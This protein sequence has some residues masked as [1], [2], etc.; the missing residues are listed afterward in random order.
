M[1]LTALGFL[2]LYACGLILCLFRHPI[3]GLYSYIFV[4][5]LDAPSRWWGASLPSVRWTLVIAG[6]TLLS[7]IALRMRTRPERSPFLSHP[8]IVFFLAFVAL[9]FVQSVWVITEEHGFGLNYFTK[10]AVVLYL[11]YALV[12]SRQRVADFLLCHVL[13]CF[14]LGLLAFSSKTGGRLDGV[15]GPGIDDSSTLGM[16]MATAVV[17]AATLY[18]ISK[19][20]RKWIP[21]L[22][23]PFLLNTVVQSGSR[24]AFLALV[25]GGLAMFW[26]RP[27]GQMGVVLRYGVLGLILFGYVASDFFWER[28]STIRAAA[29]QT[30]EIDTSAAT[31]LAIIEKQWLMA[32]DHPLGVGHKGTLALGPAYLDAKSMSAQGGRSSHNTFMSALVDQGFIGLLLWVLVMF[33]LYRRSKGVRKWAAS[34]GNTEAGWLCSGLFGMLCVIWS[35]GMFASFIRVEI[36]IW[37][38][39]LTCCLFATCS[40][41]QQTENVSMPGKRPVRP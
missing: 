39:A 34:V 36:Y 10:Y 13:G 27:P 15:G 24:G 35:G 18:L 6:A 19:G 31:R 20:Y 11:I 37:I 7:T 30:E 38:M 8:P 33:T 1:S 21:V 23:M 17:A 12:D 16:Q 41:K 3:W 40:D 9:M 25:V 26:L 28:M 5:Y 22:A 4:F 29:E 2:G 14:Y 32:K